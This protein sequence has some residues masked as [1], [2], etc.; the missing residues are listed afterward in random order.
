MTIVNGYKRVLFEYFQSSM[1]AELDTWS[2]LHFHFGNIS[3]ALHSNN[4]LF[5]AGEFIGG[6]DIMIEM[7]QSGELGEMIEKIRADMI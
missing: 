3:F 6:S 2:I 1:Q 4:Q 7:Y 5:V